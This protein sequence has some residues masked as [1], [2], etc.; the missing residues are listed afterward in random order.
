MTRT[1][2]YQKRDPQ[3][4]KASLALCRHYDTFSENTFQNS[5]DPP[6]E[7]LAAHVEESFVLTHTA[8]FSAR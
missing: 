6:N 1:K 3:D 7:W 5:E 8:A 2:I 4:F